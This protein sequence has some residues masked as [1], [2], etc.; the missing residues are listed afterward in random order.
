[1]LIVLFFLPVSSSLGACVR[2]QLKHLFEG[3]G[4]GV[5]LFSFFA[6]L[7]TYLDPLMRSLEYLKS[8]DEHRE[9][10]SITQCFF[11]RNHSLLQHH[12]Y[13]KISAHIAELKQT[14]VTCILTVIFVLFNINGL[15]V[16]SIQI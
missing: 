16:C 9:H 8:F 13:K 4:K 5:V 12:I 1:M 10:V 3:L 6:Q 15:G 7:P 2:L 14:K 11:I